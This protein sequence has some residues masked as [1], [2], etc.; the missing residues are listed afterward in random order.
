MNIKKIKSPL[1]EEDVFLIEIDTLEKAEKFKQDSIEGFVK[2]LDRQDLLEFIEELDFSYQI[3]YHLKGLSDDFYAEIGEDNHVFGNGYQIGGWFIEDIA[4]LKIQRT[5]WLSYEESGFFLDFTKDYEEKLKDFILNFY[6]DYEYYE[7]K[8]WYD[9]LYTQI[10]RSPE[11]RSQQDYKTHIK[12]L[13]E[14]LQELKEKLEK[15]KKE[16]KKDE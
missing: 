2:S 7:K 14:K 10:Q 15:K 13:D 16:V 6:E 1:T 12:V 9:L 3:G 4:N 8:D 11:S 5:V